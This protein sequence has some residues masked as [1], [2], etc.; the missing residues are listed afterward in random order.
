M[1]NDA[2]TK[3]IGKPLKRQYTVCNA[4]EQKMHEALIKLARGEE[5]TGLEDLLNTD[6]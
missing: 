2:E 5:A 1:Y 3:M 4:M 6:D